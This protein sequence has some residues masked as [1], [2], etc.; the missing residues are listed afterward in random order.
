M[1]IPSMYYFSYNFMS[2][3]VKFKK[4]SNSIY[5]KMAKY[6]F[7]K[8]IQDQGLKHAESTETI[9]KMQNIGLK[10]ILTPALNC[11][12]LIP[13]PQREKRLKERNIR[14]GKGLEPK[15]RYIKARASSVLFTLRLSS[16]L[17]HKINLQITIS[18]LLTVCEI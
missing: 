13:V 18:I 14:K 10:L 8:N 5:T 11:H 15:K 12:Q 17:F 9:D 4:L 2:L 7:L 1:D 16:T 3:T 6:P